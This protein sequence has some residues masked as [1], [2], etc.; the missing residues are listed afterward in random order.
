MLGPPATGRRP[1]H[2]ANPANRLAL[3]PFPANASLTAQIW[4]TP[5]RGSKSQQIVSSLRPAPTSPRARAFFATTSVGHRMPAQSGERAP[6]FQ[7][8]PHV[9]EPPLFSDVQ[10]GGRFSLRA[11]RLGNHRRPE[12]PPPLPSC[13]RS[14]K[15]QVSLDRRIGIHRETIL[16]RQTAPSGPASVTPPT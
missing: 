11:G 3:R 7:K 4:Q 15:W 5:P 9:R 1:P 2:S 14:V 13:A 6:S 12:G 8:R 16:P 10:E